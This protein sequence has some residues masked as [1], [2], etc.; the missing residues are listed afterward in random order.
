MDV[1]LILILCG[2]FSISGA[3]GNWDWFMEGSKGKFWVKLLGRGGARAFYFILGLT[4]AIY[5][6]LNYG[7]LIYTG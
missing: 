4:L 7:K 6:G 1:S 2:L 3:I 5:G